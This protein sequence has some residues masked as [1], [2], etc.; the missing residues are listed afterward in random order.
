MDGQKGLTAWINN[1]VAFVIAG[2]VLAALLIVGLLQRNK[3]EPDMIPPAQFGD[4]S[5]LER[6]AA[7]NPIVYRHVSDTYYNY[8]IADSYNTTTTE[9]TEVVPPPPVPPPPVPPPP[10]PPPPAPPPPSPGSSNNPVIPYNHFANHRFP[11][12]PGTNSNVE[13]YTYGGI[14]YKVIPGAGGRVWGVRPDGRQVLL[15]APA[16]YYR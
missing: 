14:T 8:S 5:G 11:V 2:V 9:T 12:K 7:G 6:D 10:V 3:L 13:N 15:Y 1:N 16:S 4:L